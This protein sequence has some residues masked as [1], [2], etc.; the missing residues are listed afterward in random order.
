MIISGG[1]NI[2]PAEVEAALRQ[3]PAV[4]E[5][6]VVGLPDEKWGERVV[7]FVQLRPGATVQ[8]EA[9]IAFAAQNI[10]RF[11]CPKIVRFV[12]AFPRTPLGKIQRAILRR[13]APDLPTTTPG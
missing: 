12:E 9:L 11:K 5:S 1:E 2:Y 6:A 7:A 8:A 4:F 10:A 13:Q 3:H